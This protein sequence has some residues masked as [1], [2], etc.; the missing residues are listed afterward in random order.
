M[1]IWISTV[2]L[3]VVLAAI[4]RAELRNGRRS[5]IKL[6][7]TDQQ[8]DDLARTTFERHREMFGRDATGTFPLVGAPD[9]AKK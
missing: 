2:V 3:V 7:R 4:V 9:I 8:I 1:G 5:K 6:A